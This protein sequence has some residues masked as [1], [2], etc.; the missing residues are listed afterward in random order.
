MRFVL[1]YDFE[2]LICRII[3]V[4]E[5]EHLDNVAGKYFSMDNEGRLYSFKTRHEAFTK[6]NE[7]WFEDKKKINEFEKKIKEGT[8]L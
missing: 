8:S 2:F 1:V 4:P 3:E 6:A 7:L 5:G